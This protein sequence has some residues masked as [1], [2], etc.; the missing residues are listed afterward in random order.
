MTEIL[1][2]LTAKTVAFDGSGGGGEIT[3][4]MVAASLAGLDR[5]IVLYAQLKFTLD[6]TV[7]GELSD[8]LYLNAINLALKSG[9]R[10]AK[11][12][13]AE[14][15]GRLSD[16]ALDESI[17]P[18]SCK[19]CSGTGTLDSKTCEVCNGAGT[20]SEI[21]IRRIAARLKVTR[22]RAE[23]FWRD[24]L[25]SLL[26]DHLTWEHDINGALKRLKNKQED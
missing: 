9:W 21:S 13:D 24:K 18:H 7:A 26:S 8:R 6:D 3:W 22:H 23:F 14:T 15:I 1:A 2:M 19:I 17:S 16:L 10:L 5:D 20:S 12:E 11:D 4:D 25:K